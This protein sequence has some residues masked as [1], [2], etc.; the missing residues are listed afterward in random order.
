M[1]F[2]YS[3]VAFIDILGY[4]EMIN[5]DS[6]LSQPFYLPKLSQVVGE[7]AAEAGKSKFNVKLFSDCMMV[8]SPYSISNTIQMLDLIKVIQW[9]FISK[10]VLVRGGIS[11]GKHFENQEM[12]FSKGLVTAYELESK[13]A[14][15][16]R[17]VV[18]KNLIELV[19]GTSKDPDDT[20][21][22]LNYSLL[23]DDDGLQFINYLNS[24]CIEEH[25]SH[26]N[27]IING[28]PLENSR[29]KEKIVWLCGYHNYMVNFL[30][31]GY[32]IDKFSHPRFKSRQ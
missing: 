12:I 6:I 13:S 21:R 31:K 4:S 2:D 17:I 3:I 16:P 8:S 5:K 7:A 20:I 24:D 23:Y 29:V 30:K 1:Q 22:N 26:V 18:D 10:C 27:E 25:G 9:A 28:S 15:Y 14:K 19:E 32:T 11:Y